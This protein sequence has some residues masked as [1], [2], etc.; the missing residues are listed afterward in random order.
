M[1]CIILTIGRICYFLEKT[2][3]GVSETSK[4]ETGSMTPKAYKI[5]CLILEDN[6][7]NYYLLAH[8]Y[9]YFFLSTRSNR[10]ICL[11]GL[12]LILVFHVPLLLLLPLLL[13]Q[14]QVR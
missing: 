12:K 3:R 9:Y 6:I 11:N 5:D 10:R 7:F 4:Y 14:I 8:Y 2:R 13:N 1:S